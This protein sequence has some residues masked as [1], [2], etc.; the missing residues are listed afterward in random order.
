[1]V[2]PPSPTTQPII[3]YLSVSVLDEMAD[4]RHHLLG[5]LEGRGRGLVAA[6]V[7]ER[8]G[9]VPEVV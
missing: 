8:P 1:M 7:G 2:L 3:R 5:R 9:N 6:E 4:G